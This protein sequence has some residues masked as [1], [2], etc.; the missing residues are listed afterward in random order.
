MTDDVLKLALSGVVGMLFGGAINN[1]FAV[2]PLRRE[3][4]A[5][6][7]ALGERLAAVEASV[8][9]LLKEAHE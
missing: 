3:M 2:N 9:L 1:F 8:R 4:T 6:H 7:Q 5:M